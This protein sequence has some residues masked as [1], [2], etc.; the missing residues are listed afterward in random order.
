M[1]KRVTIVDT[2]NLHCF[3]RYTADEGVLRNLLSKSSWCVSKSLFPVCANF[4]H[5][6]EDVPEEF[7]DETDVDSFFSH[8]IFVISQPQHRIV[9]VSKG[10]NKK[11]FAIKLFLFWELKT[12][13]RYILQEEVENSEGELCSLVDRLRDFLRTLIQRASVYRF[14][15]RNPKKK[16]NLQSQKRIF[17]LITT[18]ISLNIQIHIFVYRSDSKTTI[19]ASRPSKSLN[20]T[21]INSYLQK[22]ST[23]TIVK[24][25]TSTGT[26][27]TLQTSEIIESN[28]DV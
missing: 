16:L 24:F 5:F 8:N 2:R 13:Q 3:Y 4:I 26:D 18:K 12:Q 6:Y 27:F 21:V 11:S 25:T 15:Y 1:F 22:L 10:S 9:G 17:L 7:F 14:D 23:L 28:Y 20:Y 19:V